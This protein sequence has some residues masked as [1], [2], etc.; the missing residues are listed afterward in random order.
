MVSLSRSTLPTISITRCRVGPHNSISM[1]D[2]LSALKRPRQKNAS[3]DSVTNSS[4]LKATDQSC[5]RA[6]SSTVGFQKPPESISL[7]TNGSLKEN[8]F[9]QSQPGPIDKSCLTANVHSEDLLSCSFSYAPALSEGDDESPKC[10]QA[11]VIPK[12]RHRPKAAKLSP[13]SK[14]SR[15]A[16]RKENNGIRALTERVDNVSLKTTKNEKSRKRKRKD[17]TMKIQQSDETPNSENEKVCKSKHHSR[18]S[19]PRR[20]LVLVETALT[21]QV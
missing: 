1:Q 7:V 19:D 17:A 12:D 21:S 4:S 14:S 5:Q 9:F 16:Q 20:E 15:L 13:R 10:P 6:T 11:V 2:F 8:E 18:R 3:V